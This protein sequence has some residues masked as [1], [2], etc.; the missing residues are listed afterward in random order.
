MSTRTIPHEHLRAFARSALLRNGV[1]EADSAA[2]ADC[3]I[4]ANLAGVDSHGIVHLRHYLER[5]ANGTIKG[6][7]NIRYSQPKPGILQVDG[8]DGLGHAVMAHAVNHG[9]DVCRA[10]GS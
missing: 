8:D 1:P 7:P 9:I 5:L 6:N 3:L 2:V 10:E 4:D